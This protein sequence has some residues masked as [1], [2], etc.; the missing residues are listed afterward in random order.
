MSFPIHDGSV[1]EHFNFVF[2]RTLASQVE[3]KDQLIEDIINALDE[4]SWFEEDDRHWLHLCLD[5]AVVN[6]MIHGNE[7]DPDLTIRV[8]VGFNP[9]QEAWV[10]IIEDQGDGFDVDSVPDVNNPDS[11]LLEHGR[12][13][14]LMNEWLDELHYYNGGSTIFMSRACQKTETEEGS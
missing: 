12:G 1:P 14:L 6:A 13:I 2:D 4:R 10:I 7:G 5:E 11:L 9:E 8:R 3:L